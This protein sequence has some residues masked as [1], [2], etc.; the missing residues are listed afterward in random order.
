[1]VNAVDMAKRALIKLL[2][3][4]LALYCVSL[5]VSRGSPGP[6]VRAACRKVSVKAR[7]DRGGNADHQ[8]QLNDAY[9]A[10]ETAAKQKK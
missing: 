2:R 4:M 8:Q 10:W 1:M 6:A 5:T 7:P 3:E 9:N